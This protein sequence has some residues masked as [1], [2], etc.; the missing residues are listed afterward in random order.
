MSEIIKTT[1]LRVDDEG[2]GVIKHNGR[3]L[4]VKYLLTG[5]EA[6]IELTRDGKFT[7]TKVLN[8]ITR[9]KNRAKPPCKFYYK[10]GGCQIQHMNKK[11]Q[12]EFKLSIVKKYLGKYVNIEGLISMDDPYNYRNKAHFTF[13]G[14]KEVMLSLDS[15]SSILINWLV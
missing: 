1:C 8:I 3:E 2:K 5:E 15:M 4:R 9:S 10:C 11:A 6:E 12:D 14:I 7:D 13:K